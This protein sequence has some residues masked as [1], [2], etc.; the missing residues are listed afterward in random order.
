MTTAVMTFYG[1]SVGKKVVMAATGFIVFGFV[2]VHMIGNLQIFQ[3]PERLNAYAEFLHGLGMVLWVFRLV[4]LASVILHIVA[5]T[6]VTLQSWQARPT[7]YKMRRYRETTYAARTMRWGGPIIGL[8]VV[9]HLLHF[10]SGSVHPSFTDNV[11]NNVIIGFQMPCVS[12]LYIIAL[13][14]VGL[15]LYHGVWSMFQSIGA[16]HPKWNIWRRAVA[17]VFALFVT[18]AGASIPVAVLAGAIQPV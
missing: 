14:F 12:I 8:F 6:Q 10:T 9:Y 3:G 4:M 2:T 15:H 1:T 18:A 17:V 7:K 13:V 11:Y 5:A 16:N